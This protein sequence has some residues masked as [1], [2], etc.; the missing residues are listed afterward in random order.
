MGGRSRQGAPDRN[1]LK[2]PLRT[3]RASTRGMPRGLVGSIAR[4]TLHSWSE[5]S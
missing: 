4:M 1:T 3:R 5:S 2:M